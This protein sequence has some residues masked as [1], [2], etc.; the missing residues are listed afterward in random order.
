VIR[1]R[2][3]TYSNYGLSCS[4]CRTPYSIIPKTPVDKNDEEEE[5]EEMESLEEIEELSEIEED[6]D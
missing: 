5:T 6:D 3:G 2:C 1:C 4:N